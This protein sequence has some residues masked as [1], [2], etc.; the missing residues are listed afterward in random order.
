MIEHRH[1]LNAT[2]GT[3]RRACLLGEVFSL[4]MFVCVLLERNPGVPARLRAI[5]DETVL[6]DVQIAGASPAAPVIGSPAR[7]IFLK[8]I[9]TAVALLSGVFDFSINAFLTTV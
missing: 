5:V 6:A 9:Q 4:H 3:C 2:N 1:L 8:P 7:E